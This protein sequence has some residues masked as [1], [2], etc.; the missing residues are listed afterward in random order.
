[1]VRNME[2]EIWD[3]MLNETLDEATRFSGQ[4]PFTESKQVES[5]VE[6]S[7]GLIYYIQKNS[8]DIC[9]RLMVSKNLSFDLSKIQAGDE[10][11]LESLRI[12]L[13]ALD[14][15]FHFS[16]SY[17]ELAEVIKEHL[18]LKRFSGTGIKQLGPYEED[19][20][21]WLEKRSNSFKIN[22]YGNPRKKQNLICLGA[23]GD[24]NIFLERFAR[25]KNN[26]FNE[27]GVDVQVD[28]DSIECK[29]LN[30][31]CDEGVEL[32]QELFLQGSGV[33]SIYQSL[34]GNIDRTLYFY[35]KE[36][37]GLRSFWLNFCQNLKLS[38]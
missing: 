18:D 22:L 16:T 32:L 11:L 28:G 24:E 37:A 19:N 17:F 14:E 1:M 26:F 29:S 27:L 25:S 7:T 38:T 15:V 21:W 31:E 10:K 12:P 9:L 34:N 30:K 23:L 8:K 13:E 36:L 2:G 5:I 35:L 20:L 33:P 4:D 6:N 3:K